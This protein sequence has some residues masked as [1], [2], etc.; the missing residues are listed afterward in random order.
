MLPPDRKPRLFDAEGDM[1]KRWYI[2]FQIWDTDKQKYVRKQY[3]GMNKYRSLTERRRHSNA[4]LREITQLLLDGFTAG[5]T[6]AVNIGL[7]K[8]PTVLDAVKLVTERK[9]A[10][11]RKHENYPRLLRELTSFPPLA[12]AA[13]E[14]A[15]PVNVLAFLDNLA[16][17][18]MEPKTYNGYRDT[19]SAVFN[20]LLKLEAVNRNPVRG[21]DRRKVVASDMHQP[22][23]EQQRQAIR[24]EIAR[25]DDEQLQ[26]FISFVY[27]CFIRIGS[28]LRLLQV[29]D[30]LPG[31]VRVPGSRAKNDQAEHVAIPRQLEALIQQYGLRSYPADFYVF[32]K[33]RK[34]GPVAV[35]KNWFAKRHRAILAAVGLDNGNYTMYGYKHTGAINLYL[36][37]KDIELVRRHC[38]HTHAGIT[39]TYLRKLGALH[40]G[41]A[42]DAMPDF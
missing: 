19:L 13:L 30:L 25:R 34:P 20:Y 1:T 33:G 37:T 16:A 39:A 23:T 17:R 32:T 3:T 7:P 6:P 5:T 38:R 35:G 4:K 18:G 2:D 12:N 27:Y 42:I 40:D 28:E 8:N 26:L 9:L 14:H 36:A 31:T 24:E 10:S 11:G 22:Y 41:G 29:R 21:V 15:R